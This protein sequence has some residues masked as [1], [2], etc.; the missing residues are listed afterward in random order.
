MKALIKP[1]DYLKKETFESE[2]EN[3]FSE[4][5][6]FVAFTSD[7]TELNDFVV[8]DVS[9]VPV[10]VQNLKGKIR[11]F[12]NVCSHRH[13]LIQTQKKGNR[14]L[15]C[16]YHGWAY[17]DKGIPF[18]IPKKPLFNFTKEELECL[19]L[20]EYSVEICGSLVFLKVKE[21]NITLQD[22][23]GE[24][25]TQIEDMSNNFGKLIDINQIEIDCNWKIVVENTLESYHVALIHSETFQKLGAEGLNFS[26]TKDH[27]IWDATVLMKEN[28]GKQAKVHKSFQDRDYKIDGYKHLIIFPNILI[29]STYGIS[30]NLSHIIP[31]SEEKTLF[32]SYVFTTKKQN[33]SESI[34]E[35][36][37]EQ[38]LI[39]FNRKVFDEDK[40][41]CEEVQ[42]GVKYS[43]Y[44]GELSEEEQRVLFF[45]E[46]YKKY[47]G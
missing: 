34:I 46:K 42:K 14:P 1:S 12:K 8:S 35:K 10:V 24:I 5:W 26:F 43:S 27:S 11:A 13:S 45:Q 37:Y 47:L 44:D 2:K 29:S 33:T 30:F 36:V 40:I 25:Y 31:I 28:E 16:P 39:D 19:K 32:K 7:F 18:G 21:G 22:Y 17:S 38:S 9:G 15:M 23:L 4:V 41:I 6:N 3:L 20:Q